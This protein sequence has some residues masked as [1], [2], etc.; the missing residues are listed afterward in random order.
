MVGRWG[1]TL[2]LSIYNLVVL[3]G[4]LLFV[5]F[6]KVKPNSNDVLIVKTDGIG[7]YILW[8]ESAK[9]LRAVYPPSKYHVTLLGNSIWLDLAK[10]HGMFDRYIPMDIK[11]LTYSFSYRYAKLKEV[12]RQKYETV[13]HPVYSRYYHRG[14]T[15]VRAIGARNVIGS[16]GDSS[17]I[18]PWFKW[19]SDR[20][21]TQLIP[22]SAGLKTELERNAEF[23]EGLGYRGVPARV[24]PIPV[25]ADAMPPALSRLTFFALFPGAG[26]PEK[27][28]PLERF[29]EIAR[30]VQVRTGWKAVICG[31]KA[32]APLGDALRGMLG[33]DAQ[34]WSGRTSLVELAAILSR[35]ALVI[36]NDT[37]AVHVASAVGAPAVCILAGGHYGRFLPYP[38]G[39]GAGGNAPRVIAAKMPCFNCN[40]QCTHPAYQ[41]GAIPCITQ[42]PVE[43][44]WIEI[45]K[46]ISEHH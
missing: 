41:G 22:V 17:N 1:K 29:A 38:P 25:N 11:R 32:D 46:V 27:Q 7:D 9:A 43:V 4:D 21:Y 10:E 42:I 24:P 26:R 23:M 20:W 2:V 16:V 28:W 36:A 3:L 35:A 31:G 6:G 5:G 13:I 45:E 12:R 40:W 8:L 18:L 14:D 15:I 30:R 33:A 44:V 19:V 39:H 34:N 37:G